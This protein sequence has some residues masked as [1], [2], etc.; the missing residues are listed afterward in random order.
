MRHRSE[1]LPIDGSVFLYMNKELTS[2][3][4][5]QIRDGFSQKRY[6]SQEA[7]IGKREQEL[8]WNSTVLIAGCGAGSN[9]AATLARRGIGG[10]VLA[11]FDVVETKNTTRSD[12]KEVDIGTNKA[13]ALGKRIQEI[14][15]GIKVN[16][17]LNGITEANVANLVKD[18]SVIIEMIDISAPKY[19]DL[20]HQEAARQGK[21]IVT[22][23]DIGDAAVVLHVFDYSS[24]DAM[25]WRQFLGLPSYLDVEDI[26]TLHPLGVTAQLIRGPVEHEFKNIQ[27]AQEYY[28]S[29]TSKE[30]RDSLKVFLP[31]ESRRFVDDLFDGKLSTV[32]QSGFAGGLLGVLQATTVEAVLLGKDV[33]SAPEVIRI[34]LNDVILQRSDSLRRIGYD[35]Y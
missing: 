22:G 1:A 18:A 35:S 7:F 27:S 33:R 32:P 11:D 8:L 30:G 9:A 5:D 6:L 26:N 15:S 19:I 29:A 4:G 24:K 16:L 25:T 34:N 28:D 20:L 31:E 14:N 13:D 23:M 3:L 10:F 17:D 12:Y 21:P 2:G